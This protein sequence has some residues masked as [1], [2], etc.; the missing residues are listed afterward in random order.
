MSKRVRARGGGLADK[1]T[2]LRRIAREVE[3]CRRCRRGGTGKAVVGEGSAD[4]QIVFVGEAPGR[5]E[6]ESG[7]P[8]VGHA[9]QWLRRAIR[10]IG[11]N[12]DTV[13]LT[14]PIKYRRMRGKPTT[15][16]IAHSR[17]HLREQI[18]IIN[19]PLVVLLGSAACLGVLSEKV[20]VRVRH[21]NLIERDGRTYL[22]TCHPAA[23]ARFPAIRR[24]VQKD[25]RKLRRLVTQLEDR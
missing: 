20:A 15:A 3:L 19:P 25:F 22:I 23:A 24:A 11:L 5:R 16:D 1:D 4:A 12:E 9:G 13:Y 2:A 14:S 10:G 6:A 8:F 21:G 7:R 18:D 17:S